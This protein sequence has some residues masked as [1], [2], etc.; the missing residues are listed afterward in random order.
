MPISPLVTKIVSVDPGAVFGVLASD[1]QETLDNLETGGLGV[2]S[3]NTPI[4]YEA[5]TNYLNCS[6][7]MGSLMGEVRRNVL[8]YLKRNG[9]SHHDRDVISNAISMS[10]MKAGSFDEALSNLLIWSDQS[11]VDDD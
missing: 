9:A 7:N 6:S 11:E 1:L 4:F 3:T 2:D 10:V 5:P 8:T